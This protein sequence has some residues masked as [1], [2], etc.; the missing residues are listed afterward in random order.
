M[1]SPIYRRKVERP[2]AARNN[3]GERDEA[4]A[5]IQGLTE[6]IVHTPGTTRGKTD[7]KLVGDFGTILEWTRAGDRRHRAGAHMPKIRSRWLR[8]PATTETDI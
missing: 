8:A 3:S 1:S 7:A 5:A 6:R 2:A 4:A